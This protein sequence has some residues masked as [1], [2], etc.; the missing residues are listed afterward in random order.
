[1]VS[2]VPNSSRHVSVAKQKL[3][4][5]RKGQVY[6]LKRCMTMQT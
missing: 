1:M 5:S 2:T 4:Y 6:Q 3:M